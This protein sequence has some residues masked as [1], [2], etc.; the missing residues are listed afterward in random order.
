M[1]NADDLGTLKDYDYAELKD[2]ISTLEFLISLECKNKNKYYESHRYPVNITQNGKEE[3][4]EGYKSAVINAADAERE[5]KSM[6]Y[7]F[8]SHRF[9]VGEII[10][11]ILETLQNRYELDF[12][13]LEE[14]R[15][16]SKEME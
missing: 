16:L 3:E 15:K 1:I 7:K 8:G 5:I 6:Y 9:P 14:K 11:I 10:V 2:L 4:I 13:S 12:G